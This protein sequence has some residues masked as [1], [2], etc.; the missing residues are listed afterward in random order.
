MS[1]P[2]RDPETK[3]NSIGPAATTV[4]AFLFTLVF[5]LT[6]MQPAQAQAYN[7]VHDFTG[8]LDGSLPEAG[9]TIDAGGNL[10]GAAVYGGDDR[11][12]SGFGCGTVFKLTP[13]G[14][15][16]TPIYQ[17]H[18]FDGAKPGSRPIIGPDGTLYGTTSCGQDLGSSGQGGCYIGTL[19]NLRP[20]APG[21][22]RSLCQWTET[23]LYR[24][25]YPEGSPLAAPTFD[26]AGNIYG[27]TPYGGDYDE[28]T[29]YELSR[30]N[31]GW[32]RTTL[33]SFGGPGDGT[34][35]FSSVVFDQRG[36]LYGT[37]QGT[38][39]HGGVVYELSR[40]GSGWVETIL[41]TFD[42]S[43]GW[44]PLGGVIID[45]AD[46]LSGATTG[47]EGSATVYR[48]SPSDNGWDFSVL[49]T[50]P[51]YSGGETDG[52][53]AMDVAGNLYGAAQ[54]YI[55]KLSPQPDGT[56]TFTNLYDFDSRGSINRGFDP[57]GNVIVDPS[58]NLY[59]TTLLGGMN[60]NGVVWKV[61]P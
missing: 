27:T 2:L 18:D 47:Y 35:P 59:G 1:R 31:G 60:N 42:Y 43:D 45:H 26:Q 28:G 55:F 12:C 38:Y 37:A 52:A 53:L 24:F 22:Q 8:G 3:F 16:F 44:N 48:L 49:Y 57:E 17:F 58:G 11:Y 40:S 54:A 51:G 6:A 25:T 29:V 20:P 14:S 10:Y 21:C 61:T 56:W 5:S 32:T 9:L 39:Y 19:Y 34:L 4:A 23:V 33:H 36:N 50:L 30:S 41:H 7:V 46:S 15:G 13:E